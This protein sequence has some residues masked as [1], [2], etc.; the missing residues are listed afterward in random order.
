MTH[1]LHD[2]NKTQDACSAQWLLMWTTAAY[3]PAT[4]SAEEQHHLRTFFE[5]LENRCVSPAWDYQSAVKEMPPT[6][7][8]RRSLLLW[9]ANLENK[10][11][12]SADLPLLRNT[13]F[14]T[15]TERWRFDD[16]YL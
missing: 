1:L 9:M 12:A 3:A 2:T 16:G 7:E 11:R 10:F 14:K 6:T 5:N 4:A 8:S 15:L 13:R